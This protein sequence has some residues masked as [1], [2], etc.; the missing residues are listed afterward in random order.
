MKNRFFLSGLLVLLLQAPLALAQDEVIRFAFI[1]DNHYSVGASSVADLRACVDDINTLDGLDFVVM[2]GD[3]TDFGSDA[4]LEGVKLEFDRLKYPYYV[5]AGNHDAKWSES[6]CNSF[7]NVFGYEQF[8]FE[9]KGWRF[10][11]TGCGPDMRMAP[12]LLP[13]ESMVWLESRTPGK[14]SIE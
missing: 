1:T 7:R 10:L 3:I 2:G 4:E 5:V 6:G 11:G 12:A 9:T 14:K 13:R 8:E